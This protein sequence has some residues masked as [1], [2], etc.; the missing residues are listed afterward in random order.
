MV[1]WE[2][3]TNETRILLECAMK[4]ENKFPRPPQGKCTT[5]LACY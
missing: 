3:T 2:G 5:N 4:P 1:V